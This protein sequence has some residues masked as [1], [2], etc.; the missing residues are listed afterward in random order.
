M[1]YSHKWVCSVVVKDLEWRNDENKSYRPR[2]VMQFC[3]WQLFIWSHVSN[4]NYVSFL[5]LKIRF[6]FQTTLDE[7]T[8]KT[9]VV[10]LKMLCNFVVDN[11]FI[12]NH[13]SKKNYGWISSHL[14][15]KFFKWPRMDNDKNQ[16]CRSQKVIKLY[17]W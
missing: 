14:K 9:K 5:K 10:D 2:R 11:F 16:S 17:S 1:F 4:K 6:F 15:F 12:W 7:E 13:L 3:S 8:S